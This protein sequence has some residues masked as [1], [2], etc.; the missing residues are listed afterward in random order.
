[1]ILFINYKGRPSNYTK[2]GENHPNIPFI[3]KK[4]IFTFLFSFSLLLVAFVPADFGKKVKVSVELKDCTATD[5]LYLYQFEGFGFSKMQAA[6]RK[7]GVFEFKMPQATAKFYFLGKNPQQLKPIILGKESDVKIKGTCNDLTKVIVG[8]KMNQDYD[9]LKEELQGLKQEMNKKLEEIQRNKTDEGA[10]RMAVFELSEIDDKRMG[11]LNKYKAINPLFGEVVAINTYLSY[12]NNEENYYTEVDY[13]ANQFFQ[14][15][16]FKSPYYN[17][18]PWVFEAFKEY[19]VTLSSVGIDKELHQSYLD[20][21]L[22]KIN[23]NTNTYQLA[24]TGIVAGL[25]ERKHKNYTLYGKRLIKKYDQSFP[26]LMAPLKKRINGVGSFEDGAVAPDF[27]Q[28]TPEGEDLKLSDLRGKVVL[29]D[30]W[31]S[32]CGPC[33]KENPHVKE[34]YEK[35]NHRGFEILGVSLDRTKASWERAIK[36]DGLEWHHVSDLKGWKNE[37]AKMY[38]V[39]SIPHTILLDQEGRII[40]RKLR[41]VQLEQV[42][43]QIFGS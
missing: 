18:N 10:Q 9:K 12:Q 4:I 20:E 29:V 36:Q 23:P 11:L 39:S 13:F 30:F 19:A 24:L 41:A 15:A 26:I 14:F 42:L 5:T 8:S 16:D 35:Y 22:S 6:V 17:H 33:R 31:A 28:K 3:M 34:L 2:I 37:V 32:W 25:D 27:V 21:R 38:S 43:A 1:L 7:S 40:A